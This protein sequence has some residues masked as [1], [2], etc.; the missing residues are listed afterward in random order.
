VAFLQL[1]DEMLEKKMGIKSLGVRLNITAAIKELQ[2]ECE[3]LVSSVSLPHYGTSYLA[4]AFRLTV[5]S[6]LSLDI[7][8]PYLGDSSRHKSI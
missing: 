3:C 8:S 4:V 7:V 1:N 2:S 6:P 5:A